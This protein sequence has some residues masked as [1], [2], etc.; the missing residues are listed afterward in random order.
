MNLLL[1]VRA[2]AAKEFWALIKQPQL[3]ILLLAG[4]VLIMVVF[5]LSFNVSGALPRAVVVVEEGSE[6]EEIF[7]Q[8][9]DRFTVRTEFQ[10][11]LRDVE[12]ANAMLNNNETDAVIIIPSEPSA[13]VSEGRQATLRVNYNNINPIFGTTVPNRAN[14]LVLDLNR[15]IVR[16]GVVQELQTI[17]PTQ[18]RVAELSE[19]IDQVNATAEDLTSEE[20]QQTTEDLDRALGNLQTTLEVIQVVDSDNERLEESLEETRRARELLAEVRDAQEDGAEALQE[21]AGTAELQ[22]ALDSISAEAAALPQDVPAR[23]LVSP[24][25]LQVDNLSPFEPDAAGFYAPSVLGLLVQHIALSLASLAIVRERRSGAY[26]FFEVSPLGAGELLAGKFVTY[27]ALVVVVN[28]AVAGVL[29]SALD[30]P[31]RGGVPMLAAVMALLSATSIALGFALS[32]VSRSMLQA[33]QVAMLAFIAGG[34]FSGFLFPLEELGQPASTLS[35]L[36][37]ATYGIRAFQDVMIRGSWPNTVDIVGLVVIFV[38]SLAFARVLM[39]RG[40]GNG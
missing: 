33:I 30:V 21:R 31:L 27:L 26:E 13:A 6:G 39:R 4:P 19:Q 40:K 32:V 1:R 15:D 29:A 16:E 7:E 36:L 23:V 20:A 18:E 35:Y 25:R 24:L 8:Y 12:E 22:A 9:R 3:L 28:L 37:P 2:V 10:G 5:A 14:G 38:V 17:R 34:F 11:V